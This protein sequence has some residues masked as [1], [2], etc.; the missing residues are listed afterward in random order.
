[1]GVTSRSEKFTLWRKY[2]FF[3][4]ILYTYFYSEIPNPSSPLIAFGHLSLYI[5]KHLIQSVAV[6]SDTCISDVVIFFKDTFGVVDVRNHEKN[7]KLYIFKLWDLALDKSQMWRTILAN[8]PLHQ[9]LTSITRQK[10]RKIVFFKIEIEICA[11]LIW[12]SEEGTLPFQ[13]Y[14][15]S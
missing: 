12:K 5:Q 1:M 4:N 14:L 15:E 13:S 9:L 11:S 10:P 2:C 8:P 3:C 7:W 6:C